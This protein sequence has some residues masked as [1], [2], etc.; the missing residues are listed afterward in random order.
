LLYRCVVHIWGRR[1]LRV[2]GHNGL[3]LAI[4][5]IFV[6]LLASGCSNLP[7]IGGGAA[8]PT[9]TSSP[10]LA[11][12]KEEA[13]ATTTA[14]KTPSPTPV[15]RRTPIPEDEK[16][17]TATPIPDGD[18]FGEIVFCEDV[19]LGYEPPEPIGPGTEFSAS[20]TR[21]YAVFTYSDVPS[22]VEWTQQ[23]IRDG[24]EDEAIV[25]T[26]DWDWGTAGTAWIFLQY[27]DSWPPG[28]YE[29]VLSVDGEVQ[30]EGQFAVE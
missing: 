16:K 12:E 10:T 8:E 19:D 27:Q 3:L 25:I 28:D 30:Q 7:F 5:L 29:L 2:K 1:L 14:T 15:L 26:K 9:A 24:G 4:S 20:S 21:V 13:D 6:S 23:W 11:P 18:L 22:D 17:E